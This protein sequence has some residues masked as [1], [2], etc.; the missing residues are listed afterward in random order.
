MCAVSFHHAQYTLTD[1]YLE[2]I[3]GNYLYTDNTFLISCTYINEDISQCA[4]CL[5][6]SV[7][8][9]WWRSGKPE[10]LSDYQSVGNLWMTPEPAHFLD[11]IFPENSGFDMVHSKQ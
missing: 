8:H 9:R 5:R 11:S 7:C 1:H 10:D 4:G 3:L 6:G 2:T